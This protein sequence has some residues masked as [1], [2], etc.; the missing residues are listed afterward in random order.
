MRAAVSAS[1]RL[2]C[3]AGPHYS[4]DRDEDEPLLAEQWQPSLEGHDRR[5]VRMTDG[6]CATA[7][8]RKLFESCQL[9]GERRGCLVVVKKHVTARCGTR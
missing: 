3:H 6:S 4:A 1:L 2:L 8:P 5:I 7:L 9:S